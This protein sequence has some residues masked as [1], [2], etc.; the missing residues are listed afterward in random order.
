MNQL[1][2]CITCDELFFKTPFDKI[3]E[4][5]I[6]SEPS[7]SPP[8]PEPRDDFKAFLNHHQGH[9]M[10]ELEIITD[11]FASEKGYLEP[12][13]VSYFKA[14]NGKE[15]F[16][17]RKFRDRIEDPLTYELI[18]GDYSLD[19]FRIEVQS[20][21]I[22]RQMRAEFQGE[23]FSDGEISSFVRLYERIAELIDVDMLQRIPEESSHSLEVY[24]KPDD[25][26][27]AFLMRNS[28]NLFKGPKYQQIEDF[29][30][31]HKEDGVLLLKAIYRIQVLERP[32]SGKKTASSP[33]PLQ[34]E[35]I[36]A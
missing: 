27:L 31:R 36:G 20:E 12:V 34:N 35:G 5:A 9:R 30:R 14:T 23:A 1:I 17:V 22:R 4:Y 2:R 16:L 15:R 19:C 8:S 21:A 11:S 29:I 32:R 26:S 10:E 13:K 3:P 7:C 28:R 24:C 18:S 25:L 6:A 33:I